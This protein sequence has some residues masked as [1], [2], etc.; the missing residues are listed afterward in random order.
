MNMNKFSSACDA[1]GLTIS[2]KKRRSC[3]SKHRIQTTQNQ[4]PEAA[5]VDKFT[6]F[7]SILSKNS[8]IDDDSD[9]RIAKASTT[10]CRLR[11]NGWERQGINFQSLQSCIR[12][13]PFVCL[14]YMD[15]GK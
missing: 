9:I 1:F 15:L 3:F 4:P 12:D 14:R 11:K 8:L 10:F 6:Y 13:H 5:N 2:T 7:G